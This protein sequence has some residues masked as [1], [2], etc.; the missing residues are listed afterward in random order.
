VGIGHEAGHSPPKSPGSWCGGRR[1]CAEARWFLVYPAT[2]M[3]LRRPV[4][5]NAWK[6]RSSRGHRTGIAL[7]Q[8]AV[9]GGR[10][11]APPRIGVPLSSPTEK[12]SQKKETFQ[13]GSTK[14]CFV[15]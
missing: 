2:A 12:I 4:S 11:R 10:A 9:A 5:S 7:P 3:R 15:R 1:A 8:A 6:W 13:G 14:M